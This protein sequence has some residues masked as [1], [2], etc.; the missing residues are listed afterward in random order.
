MRKNILYATALTMG[1]AFTAMSCDDNNE[2]PAGGN[3]YKNPA[4][5]EYTADNADNW[6]AYMMQV[7]QLLDRD[8]TD[9]NSYWSVSYDRTGGT[10]YAQVFKDHN[11]STFSS[12]LSCVEQILDG[13]YD[14]ANEVGDAKIGDP[15]DLYV[16]GNTTEAL[17]AVESWYSWH[18]REDYSN[19]IIS[20]YNALCGTRESNVVGEQLILPDESAIIEN[21]IFAKLRKVD[22][23]TA[24]ATLQAVK[25]AHDAILNIP[26]PFRNHINSSE[27]LAAQQACLDLADLLTQGSTNVKRILRDAVTAGTLTDAELDGVVDNYV[28]VVVLPTYADL[29]AE[30]GNLLAAIGE[31]NNSRTDANFR[32]ACNA[33]LAARVPWETSEAFLFGPVADEGLDPNMDSWPLDLDGIVNTLQGGDFSGL[34]WSGEFIVDE[35]GDPIE[36]IAAVQSVRG[37]HT[38]EFLLFYNGEPRSVN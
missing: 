32:N 5:V 25:A 13:C 3:D 30:A 9:L 19:N 31:L 38:L 37:F 21:S 10:P 26:A 7:A 27:A 28:D 15:Y 22:A 23:A 36:S 24:T 6:H 20:I 8:A 17:Y 35:N 16:A 29:E 34:T 1:L 18:S 11:N 33:W 14:I 2:T 12:A 4:E